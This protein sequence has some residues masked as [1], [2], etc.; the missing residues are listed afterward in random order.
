VSTRE[1]RALRLLFLT[2]F[3]RGRA[4]RRVSKP[5][6]PGSVWK[7]LLFTLLFYAAFG[8]LA[9][10]LKG[11]KVFLLAIYLHSM[12][13]VFLGM[14]IA[15]SAGEVLFNKEEADILLHR[16]IDPRVLLWTKISVLVQV[17]LWLGGA[18][19]LGGFFIGIFAGDGGWLF[20]PAHALS[21]VLEAMF[22]TG[23]VVLT[24]QLCLRW[25][26]REKLD[27]MMTGTQV[28]VTIA[29]ML[30]T[31]L[32]PRFLVQTA[33]YK[34]V[35]Q[36]H[37]W[38]A[39]L[40]PA[41]F[42]GIDDAIAGSRSA[43]SWWLAL[44]GVAATSLVVW[45]A[46]GKLATDYAT[47]LQTVSESAKTRPARTR[48]RLV[49]R[50]VKIPPVSWWFRDRV[51]RASFLLSAAY[52][53]RDRDV[54]LRV[55]PGLAPLLIL[56]IIMLLPRGGSGGS[57]GPGGAFQVAFVGCY[58][59]L[60]PLLAIGMLRYSQQWQAADVFRSAPLSGPAEL[61]HGTRRAVLL[62]IATP[63]ILIVAVVIL[64]TGRASY[65]EM[66]LPGLI[67]MPAYAMFACLDGDAVPFS[68][69]TEEGKA[70]KRTTSMITALVVSALIAGAAA[71]ARLKGF[72]WPMIGG[73]AL[74]AGAV[75][76]WMRSMVGYSRW[77]AID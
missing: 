64:V 15:M 35:L 67:A 53:G 34:L 11:Q 70:A 19:N 73:E 77:P 21:T 18:F 55:Y 50:L 65:L 75:Y 3:L 4:A 63:L 33:G 38:I 2:L 69:P 24:Y 47:G 51:S 13:F 36:S 32:L 28:V 62:L 7:K 76:F 60:I 71:F 58:L 6:S 26:G 57:G 61:C 37:W 9:L 29:F 41:W 44:A 25:F 20:I 16:P 40:P 30:S 72:F 68:L 10:I 8:M 42:A 31:Q 14:F 45:L 27:A 12:T 5:A 43:N 54:K 17:A 1:R 48:L 46:F 56:P 22:C 66:L 74:L 52:L 39:V 23:S 49:G 59:G